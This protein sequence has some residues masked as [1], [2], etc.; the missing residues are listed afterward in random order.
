MLIFFLLIVF[1]NIL[2]IVSLITNTR[3]ILTLAI[4]RGAKIIA[5]NEKRETLL[6]A[7]DE[8]IKVLSA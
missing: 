1:R 4:S 8:T 6:L 2:T 5:I 7:P 3:L